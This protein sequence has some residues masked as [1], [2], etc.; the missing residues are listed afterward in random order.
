MLNPLSWLKAYRD[1]K[2]RNKYFKFSNEMFADSLE[3]FQAE[4][5]NDQRATLVDVFCWLHGMGFLYNGAVVGGYAGFYHI[6]DMMDKTA[7]S[8][9]T[10]FAIGFMNWP[11]KLDFLMHHGDVHGW[12]DPPGWSSLIRPDHM[13]ADLVEHLQHWAVSQGKTQLFTDMMSLSPRTV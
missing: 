4:M 5:T 12:N 2:Q 8:S 10:K 9:K 3:R 13:K 11:H 7:P 1:R 6:D